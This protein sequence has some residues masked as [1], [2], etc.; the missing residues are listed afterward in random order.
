VV[1]YRGGLMQSLDKSPDTK[2]SPVDDLEVVL[3]PRK[4]KADGVTAGD[5]ASGGTPLLSVDTPFFHIDLA[6]AVSAA[7]QILPQ[8]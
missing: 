1:P 3:A 4:Q 7:E 8:G 6:A 5:V 2:E